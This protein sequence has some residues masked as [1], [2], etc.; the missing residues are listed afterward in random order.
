MKTLKIGSFISVF[1]ILRAPVSTNE[2]ADAWQN[3]YLHGSFP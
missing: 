2:F 3:E 1:L